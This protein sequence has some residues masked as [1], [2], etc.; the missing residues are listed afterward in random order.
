MTYG[1]SGSLQ[2]GLFISTLAPHTKYRIVLRA[3]TKKREGPASDSLFV[4]TDSIAPSA[5][6]VTNV[7]C[8]GNNEIQ[9]VWRRPDGRRGG[10][11]GF[12][13]TP[14]KFYRIKLKYR[15]ST[16][17]SPSPSG[18][19]PEVGKDEIVE[20]EIMNDTLRNVVSTTSKPH[21]C[22]LKVQE[23]GKNEKN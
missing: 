7:T 16:R 18:S 13:W 23:G 22:V 15:G 14:I 9:V 10:M 19:R 20:V 4:T 3:F 8:H 11:S 21:M 12:N 1:A 17:T 5:P 2:L 6:I